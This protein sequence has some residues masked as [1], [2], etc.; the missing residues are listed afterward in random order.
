MIGKW[1]SKSKKPLPSLETLKQAVD[2][3]M[4]TMLKV[5]TD[6]TLADSPD[7]QVAEFGRRTADVNTVAER[8][9]QRITGEAPRAAPSA[10]AIQQNPPMQPSTAGAGMATSARDA[11]E[12]LQKGAAQGTVKDVPM[13]EHFDVVSSYLDKKKGATVADVKAAIMNSE[14][15]SNTL[16]G[17]TKEQFANDLLNSYITNAG[18]ERLSIKRAR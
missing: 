2:A 9:A 11:Q 16:A 12:K 7:G 1:Q 8:I 14:I 6:P 5:A 17:R 3:E 13:S 15:P 10:G 4:S 18:D